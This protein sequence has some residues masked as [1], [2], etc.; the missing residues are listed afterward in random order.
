MVL[1]AQYSEQEVDRAVWLPSRFARRMLAFSDG[2]A[3]LQVI[4][5][6]AAANFG[7]GPRCLNKLLLRDLP[8]RSS[9]NSP[10]SADSVYSVSSFNS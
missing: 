5:S 2:A 10:K 9:K 8:F 7:E 4:G 3:W 1:S 6:A